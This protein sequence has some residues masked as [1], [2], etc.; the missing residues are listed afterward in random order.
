MDLSEQISLSIPEEVINKIKLL[1]QR[2]PKLE[3]SGVLFYKVEGSIKEP[4]TMKITLKD[5]FLMDIGSKAYTA[6]DWGEDI[7]GFRMDHPE[8][9]EDDIILGHIHSHNDMQVFFSGTDWSELNDNSPQFNYYLSVIVNNYL[10]VK[11]KIA[12]IGSMPSIYKAKDEMGVDYD[13]H[14]T[15]ATP[16]PIMFVYDCVPEVIS[17][18]ISVPDEFV[19]RIA[20]IEKKKRTEQAKVVNVKTPGAGQSNQN[21]KTPYNQAALPYYG[22]PVKDS[23][24]GKEKGTEDAW[25]EWNKKEQSGLSILEELEAKADKEN[26]LPITKEMRFLAYILRMGLEV[27]EEDHTDA[28]FEVE[29][30]VNPDALACY[31]EEN[32]RIMFQEFYIDEKDADERFTEVLEE[33]ILI[34]DANEADYPYVTIISDRLRLMG[35]RI[36]ELQTQLN[37]NAT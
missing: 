32:Y 27:E 1:C 2:F 36:E 4:D 6:F 25:G 24:P 13:L 34:M 30:V 17:P 23:F 18:L 29:G 21:Q 7:V 9:L 31:I 11:A 15:N 16:K 22:Q 5:I 10:E 35:N 28:I 33:V 12:T 26:S 3:W 20:E 8:Y 19:N 37:E 14:I